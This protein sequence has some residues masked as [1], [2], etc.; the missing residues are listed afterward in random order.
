MTESVLLFLLPLDFHSPHRVRSLSQ[1]II[2]N[3]IKRFRLLLDLPPEMLG[4]KMR[5]Y[6]LL[7][8][9]ALELP[10]LQYGEVRGPG[11]GVRPASSDRGDELA[12][13]LPASR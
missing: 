7:P 1:N 8:R 3:I 6:S 5:L 2:F 9:T 13:P 11:L 10:G 12:D 4:N